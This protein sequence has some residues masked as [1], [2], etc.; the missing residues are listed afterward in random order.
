M[1]AVSHEWDPSDELGCRWDDPELGIAWP[2][3]APLI[4]GRDRE[5]GSLSVLRASWRAALAAAPR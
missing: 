5:L 3:S 1:Y 4:S 2:C